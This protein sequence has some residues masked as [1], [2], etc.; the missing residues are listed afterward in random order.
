MAYPVTVIIIFSI[1]SA[2]IAT[3]DTKCITVF[4]AEGFEQQG[5]LTIYILQGCAMRLQRICLR[6]G[7]VKIVWLVNG[8]HIDEHKKLF[9]LCRIYQFHCFFKLVTC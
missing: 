6:T 9:L 3:D 2:V 8:R 7:L 1:G 4:L 5:Q